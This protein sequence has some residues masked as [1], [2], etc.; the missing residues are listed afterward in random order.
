MDQKLLS[1]ALSVEKAIEKVVRQ[2]RMPPLVEQDQGETTAKVP[3]IDGLS[4]EVRR[5]ARTAEVRCTFRGFTPNK[6]RSL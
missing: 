6:T 5:I 1:K 3:F 4:Q 2:R